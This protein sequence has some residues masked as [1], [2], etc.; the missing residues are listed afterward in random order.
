LGRM[1]KSIEIKASPEKVWETLALDRLT[2]WNEGFQKNLKSVEYTS[3]V[4]TPRDKLRVGAT[5]NGISK[6]NGESAQFNFE[7]TESLDNEKMTYRFS[8]GKMAR[9][10]VS[11]ILKPIENGTKLTYIIDYEMSWGILGKTLFKLLSVGGDKEIERDLE[12]FK[13]IAEK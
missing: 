10:Q 12:R 13:N 9:V 8:F 11:N 7:I 5:A 6:K 3:K 4:R 1:E 2:E